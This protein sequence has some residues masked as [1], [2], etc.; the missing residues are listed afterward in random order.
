MLM[1]RKMTTFLFMSLSYP[2]MV[3]SSSTSYSGTISF[4]GAIIEPPCQFNWD[5]K[6][7]EMRCW[8]SGKPLH[9]EK[10]VEYQIDKPS[11]FSIPKHI[12]KEEIKWVGK[13]KKLGIVTITYH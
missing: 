13:N 8:Y 11:L 4:Y 3:N 9:K 7:T 5:E 10:T 12:G 1:L 2:V 6:H